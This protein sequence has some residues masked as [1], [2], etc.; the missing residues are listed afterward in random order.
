M[1]K[2]VASSDANNVA[3]RVVV[4]DGTT[5]GHVKL[6]DVTVSN[7]LKAPTDKLL[8]NNVAVTATAA[9]LN[10][11]DGMTSSKAELNILTGVTATAAELNTLDGI[12]ASADDINMLDGLNADRTNAAV[13]KILALDA[14]GDVNLPNVADINVADIKTL[15]IHDGTITYR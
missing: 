6:V 12:T 9:E 15:K 11:L 2:G 8:I 10:K 1:L 5:G 7:K 14:N 3:H 13:D 4:T